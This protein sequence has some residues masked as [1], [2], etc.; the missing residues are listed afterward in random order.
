MWTARA[1]VISWVPHGPDSR[2]GKPGH[3]VPGCGSIEHATWSGTMTAVVGFASSPPWSGHPHRTWRQ[4]L[5]LSWVVK[6]GSQSKSLRCLGS[7]LVGGRTGE[8]S[9]SSSKSMPMAT[10]RLH[11]ASMWTPSLA[12]QVPLCC[13]KHGSLFYLILC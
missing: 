4:V 8:P 9:G 5:P 1:W 11:Q 3:P 6:G 7:E 10:P 12:V 2:S 13:I